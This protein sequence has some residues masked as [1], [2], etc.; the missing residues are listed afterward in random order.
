MG[1]GLVRKC[2]GSGSFAGRTVAT[3]FLLISQ[4]ALAGFPGP[5]WDAGAVPVAGASAVGSESAADKGLIVDE[6]PAVP[7]K[8][9]LSLSGAPTLNHTAELTCAVT[10]EVD[11]PGLEASVSLPDGFVLVSGQLT[12][13][14][15]LAAGSG[16]ELQATIKAV[17]T[18]DFVLEAK[19]GFSPDAASWLGDRARLYVSIGEALS[20]Q[21]SKPPAFAMPVMEER[22]PAGS[23]PA[24][25]MPVPAVTPNPLSD[26]TADLPYSTSRSAR[27]LLTVTGTYYNF[28]PDDYLPSP[29][30]IRPD[31]DVASVW[32]TVRVYDGNNNLLGEG[33]TGPSVGLAAGQFEIDVENAGG[34]GFY[35]RR[36]P[37]SGACEVVKEDGS[38]YFG[39]SS[40]CYPSPTD[41][42]YNV[43]EMHVPAGADGLYKGAWRLSAEVVQDVFDRG[44]WD[45]LVG[46]GPGYVPPKATV[47]FPVEGGGAF[48]NG[49]A[50]FIGEEFYTWAPCTVQHEYG[51]F[52]MWDIYDGIFP[53]GSGG[54]HYIN[55]AYNPGM[56]W[57]EGWADFLPLI[58]QS[59]GRWP[60]PVYEWG[61][62][63]QLNLETPTWGT[64]GWDN[65]DMCEG[66]V[67]GA[68]WD[69]VD[70]SQDG[71]EAM[72][73]DF[74]TTIWPVFLT[75]YDSFKG[76]YDAWLTAGHATMADSDLALYQNTISYLLLSP[77]NGAAKPP[78]NVTFT[79]MAK[80]AATGYHIQIDR[81]STFDSAG[82]LE[83]TVTG[84]Q[85]TASLT[86]GV[87]CWRVKA[88][89]AGG[90]GAYS[91]PWSVTI[92]PPFPQLTAGADTDEYPALTKTADGRLWMVW[93]SYRPGNCDIY[94]RTSADG[95]A[96]WSAEARLTT[97]AAG[98]YYPE[99]V[100]ASNGKIWLVWTS[101]RSSN[102]DIYYKTS[103]D[104]GATWSAD[105]RLT[106]DPG[107][108]YYP[109]I[110]QAAD[111]KI[112]V[113]WSAYR[114]ANWDIYYRTTPDNGATWSA[115]TRLTTDPYTDYAPDILR[116]ADGRV[117]VAWQAYRTG[118][119]DIY[120]KNT[121][122]G[123]VNWTADT[124]L[125]SDGS[126]DFHP[127]LAQTADGKIWVAWQ[128]Y[129]TGNGDLFYKSSADGGG[130]WSGETRLTTFAG[131]DVNPDIWP[132]P[133]NTI[134]LAWQSDR[135]GNYDIWFGVLGTHAD[136]NPPPHVD[137]Y[138]HGCLN[139]ESD[140]VVTI[141]AA[142]VDETGVA[143]GTLLW[144]VNG[145]PQTDLPMYNDGT[146]GD[147]AA[148][149][150]VWTVQIGPFAVGTSVTYRLRATDVDGN[151]VS[152]PASAVAF[153][154]VQPWAVS[155]PVLLV[156]DDLFSSNVQAC[157]AWYGSALDTAGVAYDFWDTSVRGVPDQARLAQYADGAVVWMSLD[158]SHLYYGWT[159]YYGS[160]IAL[161]ALM[162]YLDGGGRLFMTGN[163]L[164]DY[165]KYQAFLAGYL[166]ATYKYYPYL[167]RVLGVTGDPI[168]DGLSLSV[169]SSGNEID[170]L[171]PAVPVFTWDPTATVAPPRSRGA[172]G[173]MSVPSPGEQ[174]GVVAY[175]SGEQP[176]APVSFAMP[177]DAGTKG[178]YSTGT[179]GLRV[180]TGIYKVVFLTFGLENLTTQSD[181]DLLANRVMNWLA[182]EV[183]VRDLPDLVV[184]EKSEHWVQGQEG[185]QYTV[186]VTVRND[187]TGTAPAGA[188][189]DLFADGRIL[190][191][192]PQELVLNLGAEV[193][194]LDPNR[195]SWAQ[196]RSVIM[197]VF[198][199]LFSFAPDLT[200]APCVAA[201]M[202]TV[203]NGGISPDGTV[204]TIH[205][206]TDV[207]WSD[208]A[209]ATAPDFEYSIKRLVS[210]DLGA[211]YASFY[212]N[213]VGAQAYYEA[214]GAT[215]EEKE[216]LRNAVG[217]TALDNYTL[218][219][220]LYGAQP[221]FLNLLA[222]WPSYPVR[223]DMIEAHGDAWAQ[224]AADRSMP[225]YIGNGPFILKQWV[226]GD[227]YTFV[228]NENY[229]GT[230][231]ELT[232][233]T[234]L[235][236]AD[237]NVALAAYQINQLDQTGVPYG[238]ESAI[239]DDP[240]LGAEVLRYPQLV[241]Y[242]FQFNVTKAP[243]DNELLRQ[244][245]STAIDR[246][247][248]IDQLRGGVGHPTTSWIPP[249][250]PG[251]DPELG[252]QY[253][254]NPTLA[255][256]LLAQ[257]GYPNGAGL[258]E[259]KYQ[260][261]NTASNLAVAQFLQSQLETNL[262]ISV[263]LVPLTSMEFVALVNNR[264]FD[265][266]YYGWGADYP[267]P[268]NWL[269]TIF[270]T[271]ADNNKNGYSN[272]LFDSLCS[273]AMQEFDDA[274]RLALWQQAQAI[275][276]DDAP[277][278]FL[279]NRETF[280][281]K[282]PWVKGQITT[283]MDGQIPGDMFLPNIYMEKQGIRPLVI[284]RDLLPGEIWTGTF[285]AVG[286]TQPGD[287]VRVL[288]DSKNYVRES[289]EGN[290]SL[291]NTF[292]DVR[293]DLLI[294][295]IEYSPTIISAGAQ[296][297]F[298]ITIRNVGIAASPACQVQLAS[299]VGPAE[300][301][302]GIP[303][304]APGEVYTQAF[305]W[306][307]YEASHTF[308]ATVDYLQSVSEPNE[309][310]NKRA[311][312]LAV[313][314]GVGTPRYGGTL[315]MVWTT[316][317]GTT[318]LDPVAPQASLS[319][320]QVYGRLLT[321]DWAKGPSG[322][323]QY[324]FESPFVL[325]RFLTGELAE[326]W[327]RPDLRTTIFHLR[328]GLKW[329]DKEPENGRELTAGDIVYSLWRA[330][331]DPR[332]TFFV[333]SNV[334]DESRLHAWAID[335]YTVKFEYPAPYARAL[336]VLG[337][338]L[339][340]SP[341]EAV[342]A[343]GGLDDWRAAVGTGPYMLWD[344]VSGSSALFCKNPD[345]FQMDPLHPQNRLPYIDTI[346]AVVITDAAT[347]LAALRTHLIDVYP[348][349]PWTDAVGLQNTNPELRVR[350]MGSPQYAYE[351]FMRTDQ[352][353][354]NDKRV[355]QALQY[356][357]D[358]PTIVSQY[359]AGNGAI[360]VW[361]VPPHFPTQYTELNL[362]PE[363]SRQMFEYQPQRAI[364]LLTEAGYPLGFS[365][366]LSVSPAQPD[367][368]NLAAIVQSYLA[369]VG[370]NVTVNAVDY[371]AHMASL[372][373][374][375]YTGMAFAY[376]GNS[377]VDSALAAANGG[378]LG[379]DG[380]LYIYN[381]SKVVDP[382]AQAAWNGIQNT[383]DPVE[384]DNIR[385]E[386]NLRE[387]DL[388]WELSLPVPSSY[389]FWC[390]WV[391][392][393]NGEMGIGATVNEFG[394]IARYAWIDRTADLVSIDVSPQDATVRIGQSVQ[395][396]ATG[397]LADQSGVDLTGSVRWTSS[398]PAVAAINAGSGLATGIRAGLAV[399]TAS[400]GGL[401]ATTTIKVEVVPVTLT[402][403]MI[404]GDPAAFEGRGVT[405]SGT[406]RGFESGHGPAPVSRSD[407]VLQ[408]ATG[409]MYVTGGTM[410]LRYPQ[411]VGKA[412]SVAGVVRVQEGVPYIQIK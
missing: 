348:Y 278:I 284:D 317:L 92:G 154:S 117:W 128:G 331:G 204:Y 161:N 410:G 94:A 384:Q 296:V 228:R 61:N 56:G 346:K 106:T 231:P 37:A 365:T 219:I 179:A 399:I 290:N 318:T 51:H 229:W 148:G 295:S 32:V 20:K 330:Q 402:I 359:Y 59:Y 300:W 163:R 23:T 76:F 26:T 180:D 58:V 69:M 286:F 34:T 273:Q 305:V 184:T 349:V 118:G 407:W 28:V 352:A 310:N 257:A 274:A 82:L 120:I 303:E 155:S 267:D 138:S 239:M 194:T 247:A 253:T 172:D 116:T 215:A 210:P 12:A 200:V 397:N 335:N 353:P 268:E 398:N 381:Y 8:V 109:S 64:S 6:A 191:T 245:L 91:T 19:A 189:C 53:P 327:E 35:L 248:F 157:G 80:T 104:N 14:G 347:R 73:V 90:D 279:F 289:N 411:D 1:N 360:L 358:E 86:N 141:T 67:A 333:S 10:S 72:T 102:Y 133:G 319:A 260:Y 357:I 217:V 216:A 340:I 373:A 393:Y 367:A 378:V 366:Q 383:L 96:T 321:A 135:A 95:G 166:H 240:V 113:A 408:D 363:A 351:I 380:G 2:S 17:K 209:P 146:H 78:G 283:G 40:V 195:A 308:N 345:Y 299:N 38:P 389:V 298:S 45:F 262:G 30:N 372:F 147:A 149:D 100:Q 325:D 361:P 136:S 277:M 123:G 227:H 222:M 238:T 167:Y 98:D 271:G 343:F 234:Y 306:T 88:L 294:E 374:K 68:L 206:R 71:Y 156:V 170:P 322:S 66:R 225:Y 377:A 199:G 387:I 4:I 205:L 89:F 241:T 285:S 39:Q 174:E 315:T 304:L 150:S 134:A 207:T 132:V 5:A 111:G 291:T 218:R 114:S 97:D 186:D 181:R 158:Y 208:G 382:L 7:V 105:T 13:L 140:D 250:M 122:N 404:K 87:W 79:W 356:A 21:A 376:W 44:V 235:V 261:N 75:R 237:P 233:I 201:V 188:M 144:S 316:P 272:A 307:A 401:T 83:A 392:G 368:V 350:K 332:S 175:G 60:C 24:V 143:G 297:T 246:Q 125:V 371:A 391:K 84:T 63:S 165:L 142:L 162:S 281:V 311:L 22:R 338:S 185:L 212:F 108:D 42:T 403:A 74:P 159:H 224:P 33:L 243:F 178:V 103:T 99:I 386:E 388:A 309:K 406:Y 249:G 115:E 112:W 395:F 288:A 412:I 29:G 85:Y 313:P 27:G 202:P 258:P 31:V 55:K 107:S 153:T 77:P 251:Y 255:R 15:N 254:F 369:A 280:A 145:T 312:P 364:Q 211:D 329:Q 124:L 405:L 43:G 320:V 57:S 65:G 131:Y 47:V 314:S 394:G 342:K 54:A 139:P 275:M 339:Y 259:L 36:Y 198:Q 337:L 265:W 81:V 226:P 256:Q 323:S 292:T 252:S 354:F 396:N 192:N 169:Y 171:S 177:Q 121:A 269:P 193:T 137:S 168:G 126:S 301:H 236:I 220:T 336:D 328:Q 49:E 409:S 119:S 16:L 221:A 197:Q 385:R 326:S 9:S 362:L 190:T 264:Q 390:P 110:T 93:D 230:K 187:G 400:A 3:V 160:P 266:A 334:P 151:A 52:V 130:T 355:R 263:T 18:G 183:I 182:P 173:E 244:A 287:E 370:V 62:G 176:P 164:A 282:K 48:F 242:A 341:K 223:Q 344:C 293:P 213:I 214:T 11:A 46:D 50:I 70:A 324:S 129:R 41:T 232:R 152:A 196:D 375:S 270:G 276:V 302:T 127:S 101:Y 379:P 25:V 203:A